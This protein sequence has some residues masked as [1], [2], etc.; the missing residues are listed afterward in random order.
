MFYP[1]VLKYRHNPH[2]KFE[3][4]HKTVSEHARYLANL[5]KSLKHEGDD[6]NCRMVDTCVQSMLEMQAIIHDNYQTEK[7]SERTADILK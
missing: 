1:E 3:Q 4:I 7:E 2:L 6:S 5:A